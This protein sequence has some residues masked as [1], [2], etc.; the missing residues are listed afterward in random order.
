M[1]PMQGWGLLGWGDS[2]WICPGKVRDWAASL[3]MDKQGA[4]LNHAMPM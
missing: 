4:K 3:L 2:L 1:A